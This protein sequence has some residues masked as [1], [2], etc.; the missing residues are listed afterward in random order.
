VIERAVLLGMGVTGRAVA[1]ALTRRGIE[2]TAF[3]DR[4]SDTVAE[5]S[6]K[7]G[8]DVAVPC[9]DDLLK[10][11]QGAGGAFP[12]PGLPEHHEFFAVA[13]AAD[14]PVMSE[15]DLAEAWDDRPVAAVTGTDGKTTVVTLI[16]RM[17]TA[18]GMA[19][20]AVGNTDTPWVEAIED[21]SFDAFVVEASSFRLA[22]SQRFSPQVAVWLNFGPDHL[23]NHRSLDSYKAAKA[24]IWRDLVEGSVA[25]ANREDPVVAGYAEQLEG[26]RVETFGIATAGVNRI[27]AGHLIVANEA[28]VAIDELPRQL[29]HDLAN[30]LAASVAAIEL[31][32]SRQA[33]AEVLRGF[34][35]LRHRVEI[36]ADHDG[37]QWIND[38]KAT[39]PHA[40]AAAI[41][42]FESVVLIAGGHNKGLGFGELAA[43]RDRLKYVVGIGDA[44]E[45]VLQAFTAGPAGSAVATM[46]AA[47]GLAIDTAES[48]DTVLLSPACAS[49]DAYSSYRARGDHFVRCVK[50][51]VLGEEA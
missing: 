26:A 41:D 18:S 48:G 6:A 7:T 23:D 27:D 4:P 10:A 16:E 9:G 14:V 28:L 22:H 46:E 25:I 24:S 47:V 21:D 12:A 33:C 30:G 17:L 44:A 40:A 29:P 3:D 43:R 35:G 19:T 2:V 8:V 49:F 1:E 42:G 11:M 32:A 31:G 5:W 50:E 51:L 45:D 34:T 36:V 20:M 39:T 37:V 38:S 15:F 13:G